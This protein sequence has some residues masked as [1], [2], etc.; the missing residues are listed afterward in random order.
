MKFLYLILLFSILLMPLA[1]EKQKSS[2]F[3]EFIFDDF[4]FAYLPGAYFPGF[5]LEN[6]APDVTLLVEENN[7]FSHIDNPRV[8]FEGESFI[9]FNW[10]YDGFNVTSSL[11]PGRSAIIFPF[12][13]YS[14]YSL[15]GTSSSI[16]DPG[17]YMSSTDHKMNFS[18]LILSAVYSDLG[19]YTP[20]GPVMIQP[21]HPSLRDEMLY[22]T[23]RSIENTYFFDF[24]LNRNLSGGNLSLGINHYYIKRNFN[25]FNEFDKQFQENG[26]YLL[27]SLKYKKKI[28][29]GT[30]EI[31]GG[32]NSLKRDN[33]YAELGRLPQ[34][35]TDNNLSSYFAGIRLEGKKYLLSFS[36]ISENSKRYPVNPDHSI[37]I[38]DNDGD[39][40]FTFN[41]NGIFSSDIFSSDIRYNLFQGRS[42]DVDLFGSARLSILKSSE[43]TDKYNSIFAGNDPYQVILWDDG[44]EFSNSNFRLRTGVR[45]NW[46]V[47]RT[48]QVTGQAFL[49]L[50]SL[51]FDTNENNIN[52]Y[53]IGFNLGFFSSGKSH[54][55]YFS[56]GRT[57]GN[58]KENINYFL[59]KSGSSGTIHYWTD[60]NSDNLYQKGEEKGI[61]S[62]SG[63][64]YH[65]VD[66]DFKNPV[67]YNLI[68]LYSKKIS[69]NFNFNLKALYKQ[70]INN[71]WIKFDNEYG[72]YQ[73]FNGKNLYF[74][75]TPP[76][77][78]HLSNY[79]FDKDPFYAQ[80]L[81]NFTGKVGK[82]WFFSFSFMAHMGMGYTAFGNGPNSNDIGIINETMANPNTW[83]NGFG[84][85]DGDRGFVSKLYFGYFLSKKLFLG[86]SVKYRDGNP[87][88]FFNSQY[89][90]NQWLL[91]YSTI[92]AEDEKGIKGGP[93]ED[94]V[95]DISFKL[96]YKFRLF[97]KNANIGLSFFNILD[98]GSELSE[99]IF[100][101]GERYSIEMQI[102]KSIRLTLAFEL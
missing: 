80:L 49:G 63:N 89:Q 94:Y 58:L 100:S 22:N 52:I 91:Y 6:Y 81:L 60:I 10:N 93:R 17:L 50:S 70:F 45:F 41:R 71:P 53:D 67:T 66:P 51:S 86:V 32:V 38:F 78:F 87:F 23:R 72:Y 43:I 35:T 54:S 2:K 68:L 36:Y 59:D 29:S 61:Y 11:D 28:K 21:E 27:F 4:M 77:N 12:S 75:D 3:N 56:G 57:P 44:K 88:A 64:K 69:G 20:L 74:I 33:E 15:K 40:I 62:Y 83:I 31:L 7:G 90:N 96:S 25:D 9:N 34:E 55:L 18:R 95:S 24:L 8:Y 5:F 39:D 97:N 37:N 84:R 14:G 82:K 13:T 16:I 26:S 98:F 19:S 47:N 30:L 102:P 65:S 101:G 85:L 99:Y 73:S 42:L 46:E 48:F 79:Q 76:E 92:Q 1:G